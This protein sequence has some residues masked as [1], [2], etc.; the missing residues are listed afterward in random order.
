MASNTEICNMALSH[1]GIG[2]TLSAVETDRGEEASTCRVFFETARDATLRDFAWPF[3]TK[4]A[5]LGLVESD[6]ND[7]WAYSYRFPTDCLKLRRM[8]SGV[9]NDSRQSRSPTKIAKDTA[10]KLIFSDEVDAQAEYTVRVSDPAFFTDDF[11]LALSLR[12]ASYIAP[13]VTGGDPFKMG[14]RAMRMYLQEISVAKASALN[15]EQ[16]EEDPESEFITARN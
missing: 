13:R 14:E 3:A 16:S 9:R 5:A 7:E 15:E 11:I 1:L 6:P 12:V 10:G 2:K 8:L 4:I